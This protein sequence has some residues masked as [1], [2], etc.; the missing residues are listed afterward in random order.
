MI[1]SLAVSLGP[2]G[3]LGAT[4]L[5]G[6]PQ[7]GAGEP[8]G[9]EMGSLSGCGSGLLCF[10]GQKADGR[11]VERVCVTKEQA[12]ERCRAAPACKDTGSCTYHMTMDSCI[13]EAE[14]D[15]EKSRGCLEHGRCSLGRRRCVVR[16][17]EDCQRSDECKVHGRCEAKPDRLSGA[18]VAPF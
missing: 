8:C 10:H 18:C 1:R 15:C 17:D 11:A 13:P 9:S 4:L 2:L 7:P 16:K 5:V 6:C 3:V 12:D 14:E